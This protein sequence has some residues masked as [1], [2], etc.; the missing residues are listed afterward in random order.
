MS[1]SLKGRVT[2]E[3]LVGSPTTP[4]RKN[5]S[6]IVVN[7]NFKNK[8]H[9]FVFDSLTRVDHKYTLTL[10]IPESYEFLPEIVNSNVL[11][12]ILTP[13][14]KIA[15]FNKVDS[16]WELTKQNER[17]CYLLKIIIDA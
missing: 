12:E 6:A 3:G 10:E 4:A 9:D 11:F 13:G 7:A 5:T 14:G 15:T 17:N 2:E 1:D 8:S 16:D